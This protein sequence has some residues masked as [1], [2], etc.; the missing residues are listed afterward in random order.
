MLFNKT[1]L[2]WCTFYDFDSN[3]SAK[4]Y[5][6]KGICKKCYKNDIFC[7]V[8]GQNGCVRM[9]ITRRYFKWTFDLHVFFSIRSLVL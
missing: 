6:F 3:Y 1:H 9:Q 7:M 5:H 2:Y 4:I 8:F